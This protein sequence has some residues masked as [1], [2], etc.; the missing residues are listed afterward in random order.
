MSLWMR[1]EERTQRI[2][3]PKTKPASPPPAVGTPVPHSLPVTEGVK[4][5]HPHNPLSQSSVCQ[6]RVYNL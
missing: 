1:R 5:Y 3:S 2:R 6:I 4:I